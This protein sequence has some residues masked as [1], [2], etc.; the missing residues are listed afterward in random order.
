MG[1]VY[2][3]EK[4]RSTF[5]TFHDYLNFCGEKK[6]DRLFTIYYVLENW[7]AIRRTLRNK[8]V[9][10]CSA[11]S[12]VSH[13]LSD[14]LSSRPLSWSQ[15]GAD[16]MSKLR[17]YERNYGREKLLQLV[18]IGREER[19]LEATGTE[20]ISVKEIRLRDVLKEHSDA[21]KKY[22][23]ELQA[24]ILGETVKKTFSIRNHLRLL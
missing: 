1:K 23:D 20:G 15:K 22:I 21:S 18:R 2:K 17:C 16:K 4:V 24:S 10:G 7:A 9:Q 6:D 11:E 19:K 12:H 8:L 14:R 13:V 5:H 3:V